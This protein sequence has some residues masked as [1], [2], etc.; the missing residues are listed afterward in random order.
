MHEIKKNLSF[1]FFGT[2]ELVVPIL[3]TLVSNGYVPKVVITT[4]DRPQGRK[5]TITPP[6]AKVWALAYNIP[7]LQPEKLDS[8]FLAKMSRFNLDIGLVVAYGK[9]IPQ[10]LIDSFSKGI[11]NVHYSLLPKYRGAT[12]VEAAILYGDTET[13]VSIQQMQ[14]KLDAGPILNKR[15]T[16]IGENET[17]IELRNRLNEMAK[18]MLIET[19]GEIESETVKP[20]IQDES[21]V[22]LCK[23]IEKE[24][25]EIKLSD[26]P[27]KNYLKYRAY[28]GWPGVFF[29]DENKMRVKITEAEFSNG[30][31]KIIKV[32]P[33]GKK[34]M[35][36]GAFL[37][38]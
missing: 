31:F 13:G 30:K 29:F 32:V 35:P 22:T 12:P 11:I 5:M 24:D 10:T 2:P 28:F 15:K 21:L 6:P 33:E 36:Y 7:V 27:K 25:G 17:G 23:K 1:A 9:I 8:E 20:I 3:D 16:E 38:I 34:E 37:K 18:G 14:F 26:D 19:L 4:P